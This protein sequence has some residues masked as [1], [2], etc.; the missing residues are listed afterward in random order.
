MLQLLQ[1]TLRI[2][3]RRLTPSSWKIVSAMIQ[4]KLLLQCPHACSASHLELLSTVQWQG[5]RVPWA[6]FTA[7]ISRHPLVTTN[8][9][10]IL[11][12]VDGPEHAEWRIARVSTLV[13]AANLTCAVVHTCDAA[14]GGVE[15]LISSG[16]RN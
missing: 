5:V 14:Q 10:A 15:R 8:F 9:G 11:P 2:S 12:A 4:A 16:R 3:L 1:T 13:D 7:G 6:Q